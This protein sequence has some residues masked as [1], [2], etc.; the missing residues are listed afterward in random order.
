MSHGGREGEEGRGRRRG[1][2]GDRGR[3]GGER[4]EG[5][6]MT[7]GF[8]PWVGFH[9]VTAYV[10]WTIRALL[11]RS[12]LPNGAAIPS[13]RWTIIPIRHGNNG[14]ESV[15]SR[16][17]R[18]STTQYVGGSMRYIIVFLTHTHFPRHRA[19]AL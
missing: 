2:E 8:V 16:S 15:G 12:N 1:G 19:V 13:L 6:S 9:F 7:H 10:R 11:T 14:L 18:R 3:R 4:G 5:Y 17:S